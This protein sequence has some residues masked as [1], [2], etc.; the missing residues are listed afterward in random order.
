MFEDI[1]KIGEGAA[2]GTAFELAQGGEE[3]S[4]GEVEFGEGGSIPGVVRA[5]LGRKVGDLWGVEILDDGFDV[6]SDPSVG[7]S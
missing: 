4:S 3:D 7:E 5:R 2:G 6:G 1:G